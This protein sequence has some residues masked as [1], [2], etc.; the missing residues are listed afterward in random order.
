[1]TKGSIGSFSIDVDTVTSSGASSDAF[2]AV[3]SRVG[4]PYNP[5]VTP[6]AREAVIGPGVDV[7]PIDGERLV[8]AAVYPWFDPAH[9]H[10]GQIAPDDPASPWLYTSPVDVADQVDRMADTGIDVALYSYGGRGHATD[11]KVDNLLAAVRA[12]GRMRVAPLLELNA[13]RNSGLDA[14]LRGPWNFDHLE[15][16]VDA[17]MA[18]VAAD[19]ALFLTRGGRPVMFFYAD[20]TFS[21]ADWNRFMARIADHDIFMVTQSTDPA[22]DAD[23]V[24]SYLGAADQDEA[25][26]TDAARS[27]TWSMRL[28][29]M[30]RPDLD[31]RVV[32]GTVWPGYDDSTQARETHRLDARAGGAFYDSRW[33]A[34]LRGLPDWIVVTSWNEWWEQTHIAPSTRGGT[35][36]LE[37]TAAWAARFHDS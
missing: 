19:P 4:G 23:G 28:Q 30:L 31:P 7:G 18:D 6:L 1:M 9:H 26:Y 3:N 14:F 11:P 27:R 12:D 16:V 35:V 25:A 29:P 22:R 10:V 33:R 15:G 37:Q 5:L 32:V 8:L 21:P 20:E 34:V 36:A 24:W 2:D 17:V 13:G